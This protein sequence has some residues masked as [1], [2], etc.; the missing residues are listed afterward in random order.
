MHWIC[1]HFF[2]GKAPDVSNIDECAKACKLDNDCNYS[3]FH[4]AKCNKFA[5]C[6]NVEKIGKNCNTYEKK[7]TIGKHCKYSY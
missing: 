2:V 4:N 7:C 3:S 5:T 6:P 1:S